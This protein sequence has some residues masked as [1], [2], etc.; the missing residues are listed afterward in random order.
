MKQT[1]E[2]FLSEI[3]DLNSIRKD[4]LNLIKAPCGSGKTTLALKKLPLT[5]CVPKRTLYLIDTLAGMEQL[6]KESECQHYDSEILDPN[7]YFFSD[8]P[9][10]I[11]VITYA[12]FGALCYHYPEWYNHLDTIICDEIHKLPEMMRWEK[13]DEIKQYEHAWNAIINCAE[14]ITKPTIIAMTA[15]PLQ[16]FRKM[17]ALLRK[18]ND[19]GKVEWYSSKI[20]RVVINGK[21][22][23]FRPKQVKHYL[24]LTMLCNHLPLDKKGII[25]L[26]RISM[27]KQYSDLLER[28]GLRTAAIWSIYNTDHPM[29]E[30]QLIIRDYVINNAAIPDDVDVL[31]INKSCETSISI[32]SHIDYM[33]I[34]TSV[35]D[36]KIQAMGRYRDNLDLVY[37]YWPS[38]ND[39]IELPDKM[40][41]VALY[42]DDLEF[43]IHENNIR[44]AKGEL[45]KTPTFLQLLAKQNYQVTPGKIRCGKR[46]NIISLPA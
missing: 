32:K 41:D 2:S 17:G 14:S 22:K 21:P 8:R 15:T 45:M 27:I 19:T 30:E 29:S 10:K 6:L 46:Y 1:E 3:V 24:N 28:R 12:K 16:L 26:P 5:H 43:Y 35:Y 34:H 9:H 25:Y 37:I 18:N 20:N 40:L 42:K 39:R 44:T 23:R 13:T 33:V 31:F 36:T 4:K 38:E 7:S 11:T